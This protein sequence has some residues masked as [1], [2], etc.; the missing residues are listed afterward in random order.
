MTN[1]IPI[2]QLPDGT[3]SQSKSMEIAG[4]QDGVTVKTTTT[5]TPLM[6]FY[7]MN[8][9][10]LKAHFPDGSGGILIPDNEAWTVV[11]IESFTLS[12]PIK[13]GLN[14]TL[15]FTA[16]S[17]RTIITYTGTGAMFQNENPTNPIGTF[18]IVGINFIS[19]GVE[20]LFDIIGNGLFRLDLVTVPA[21][22][23]LGTVQSMFVSLISVGVFNINEGITFVEPQGIQSNGF[24]H[25]PPSPRS[26]VFITILS[27]GNPAVTIDGTSVFNDQAD[28]VFFDPSS[29]D[30]SDYT[31]QNTKGTFDNLFVKDTIFTGSNARE[32][33][34]GQVRYQTSGAHN[35]ELGDTVVISGYAESTYNGT[36]T[37]TNIVTASEF[38]TQTGYVADETGV[39]IITKTGRDQTDVNITA[40]NNIDTPDSMFI[41]GW[42]LNDNSEL[43]TII[44]G[45]FGAINLANGGSPSLPYAENERFILFDPD[46][47]EIQY[48]GKKQI[49]VSIE[50]I[51]AIVKTGSTANYAFRFAKSTDN[52]VS[53]DELDTPIIT[54]N[55][56]STTKRQTKLR[57]DVILNQNDIVRV[58]ARGEGTTNSITIT[59][60]MSV[61]L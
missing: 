26:L 45:T 22:E 58:E 50:S 35:Y 25:S 5:P 57:Q 46:T 60:S 28:V 19:M 55:D 10:Q 29:G 6:L 1:E 17:I 49:T 54:T 30:T 40:Q 52:G 53:F 20:S 18:R 2:S 47:G 36:K 9:D 15:E 33:G 3:A 59:G 44:D 34:G 8:E 37:V 42:F 27:T 14:S 61:N 31:I 21:F 4:E 23:S 39:G 13:I 7:A 41:G 38:M 32:G 24:S 51:L 56:V 16:S 43:T 11:I 12:T 48:K